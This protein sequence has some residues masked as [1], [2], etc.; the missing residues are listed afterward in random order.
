MKKKADSNS[1]YFLGN[2]SAYSPAFRYIND[3]APL[4][5]NRNGYKRPPLDF[6][7]GVLR[8]TRPLNYSS[9]HSFV[10]SVVAFDCQQRMSDTPLIVV[11]KVTQPCQTGWTGTYVRDRTVEN[12]SV[13]N[14]GCN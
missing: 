5:R 2:L 9:S 7:L 8:T 11:V 4:D 6:Y 1:K 10:L 13:L 14:N 3:L 12:E